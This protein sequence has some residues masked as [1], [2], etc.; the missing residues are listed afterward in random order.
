MF[1]FV[2]NKTQH[3]PA[4]YMFLWEFSGVAWQETEI[5]ARYAKVWGRCGKK[6]FRECGGDSY[7]KIIPCKVH[8]I[9]L[10]TCIMHVYHEK[11]L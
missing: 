2:L 10:Y 3:N 9:Y 11:N 6:W 4:L 5:R 1:L 8:I 7:A